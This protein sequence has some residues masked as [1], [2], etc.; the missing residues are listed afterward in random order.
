[1]QVFKVSLSNKHS[2]YWSQKGR[3]FGVVILAASPKCTGAQQHKLE[4]GHT[5]HPNHTCPTESNCES[6]L[7]SEEFSGFLTFSIPTLNTNS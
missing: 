1:M 3:N 6:N 7:R 5:D 2:G 4:I